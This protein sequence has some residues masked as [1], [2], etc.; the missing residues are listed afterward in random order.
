MARLELFPPTQNVFYGVEWCFIGFLS[1]SLN[2]VFSRLLEGVLGV[3]RCF[4][5]TVAK[6]GLFGATELVLYRIPDN[7]D[8]RDP[9][10]GLQANLA[11]APDL[12]LLSHTLPMPHVH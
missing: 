12:S 9:V 5:E 6:T 3:K 2:H 8:N 4:I 11:C 1:D 10:Y 7:T